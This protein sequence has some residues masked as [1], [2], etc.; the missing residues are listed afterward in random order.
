MKRWRVP[1]LAVAVIKDDEV[2][3]AQ[4]Y[5]VR[6]LGETAAVDEH[7]LFAI[8]SN[9][10]AFTATALGI[11][12][13]EG[14][15]DWDDRAID[16][17]DG[18]RL[19][20]PFTTAELTIRDM[21][22]HRSGYGTWMGDLIWYGSDYSRAEVLHRLRYLKPANSFRSRYGYSNFMFLAAGQVIPA[23]TGHSWEQFID[24]RIFRPLGM[25]RSNTSVRELSTIDNVASPHTEVEGNIIPIPYRNIDNC[26]PA[27]AINS[28]AIEM[29][30]WLRFQL[31]N[32]LFQGEQIV[33]QAVIRQTHTPQ[34]VVSSYPLRPAPHDAGHFLTYG[35]GWVLQDVHGRLVI[36]HTGGIDGMSSHTGVLPEI[37]LGIVVLSNY[38]S[39]RLSSALFQHIVDSYLGTRDQNWSQWHFNRTQE[40]RERA[41]EKKASE[42]L[43]K[44]EPS[45][46]PGEYAGSFSNSLYGNAT[47][48]VV[49]RALRVNLLAHES[50]EGKLEHLNHQTFSVTWKDPFMGTS[51]IT[52]SLDAKGRASGFR[53]KV[54]EDFV[55]PLE[56]EFKR[57]LADD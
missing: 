21:L 20:D 52:F 30:N 27:G 17:L 22:C 25:K 49:E 29:T 8:G 3:L 16:H 44:S 37:G 39:H 50:L 40:T 7:T 53:V 19:H 4:G 13:D 45:L 48:E 18:F 31:G 23:V 47:I 5:G 24:D 28:S 35:L 32:G 6:R 57:D 1:G 38:D 36:S 42:P 11:L 9:S 10:K 41:D 26:A 56:Y 14:K 46:P 51:L 2:V 43:Q 15:I 34:I 55:D 12:V 33:S 54:R